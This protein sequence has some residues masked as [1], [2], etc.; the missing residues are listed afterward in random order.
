[1]LQLIRRLLGRQRSTL[2]PFDF[3]R[4]RYKAKKEWPPNLRELTERQQFR[5]ERKYKR[6]L[7]MKS[8]KPAWNKWTTIVQWSLIGWVLVY[9]V[10]WYDFAKD[11]MNPRPGEQPFKGIRAWMKSW[12]DSFWSHT[13]GSGSR[14]ENLR[15]LESTEVES[16]KAKERA[17]ETATTGFTSLNPAQVQAKLRDQEIARDRAQGFYR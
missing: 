4:N 17:S 11:P 3:A 1:M 9:G 8:I 13:S 5:F 14:E 7:R 16:E 10:F 2:P 6:R 15:R 12:T